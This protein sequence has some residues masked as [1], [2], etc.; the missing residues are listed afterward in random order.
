[1]SLKEINHLC[2]VVLALVKL[3]A[4][5]QGQGLLLTPAPPV[6]RPS[7]G[8]QTDRLRQIG[9]WL[10]AR[11]P[12]TQGLYPHRRGRLMRRTAS[13]R[14]TAVR[15]RS[16]RQIRA[17]AT[18]R[19]RLPEVHNSKSTTKTISQQLWIGGQGRF[20]VPWQMAENN[21]PRIYVEISLQRAVKVAELAEDDHR[22]EIE[23]E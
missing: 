9:W 21:H 22:P 8:G 18:H 3:T 7:V 4:K 16:H 19:H 20:C 10:K 2:A 12:G 17:G 23:A 1:M 13:C 6:N 15:G 5:T 14:H 11:V